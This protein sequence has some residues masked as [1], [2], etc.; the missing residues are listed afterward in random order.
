MNL[1]EIKRLFGGGT[2]FAVSYATKAY[3]YAEF[4]DREPVEIGKLPA[5]H[6]LLIQLP[7]PPMPESGVFAVPEP[8]RRG[9]N[10]GDVPPTLSLSVAADAEQ[11]ADQTERRG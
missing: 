4:A 3:L 9:Q 11:R 7:M 6:Y 5:G 10:G 8:K 1:Q 2:F